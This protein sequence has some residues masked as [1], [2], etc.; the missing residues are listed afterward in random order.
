MALHARKPERRVLLRAGLTF[1]ALGAALGAGAGS[2]QAV[3]L[4]S[5]AEVPEQG[6]SA[7]QAVGETAAPAVTSALGTSLAGSV[8]PITDLQ[9]DPLAGTGVDP[10][11]NA[12][13]TQI[14]DF[15]PVT[16]AIL[17]DPITSGGSLSDLPV[18]GSVTKL[19]TG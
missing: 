9:L 15:K 1:T 7:L 16:T 19:V 8:A 3:S 11:D 13:G 17:T 14:A 18:V 2:A 5:A 4:P 12:V 6:V 10:L